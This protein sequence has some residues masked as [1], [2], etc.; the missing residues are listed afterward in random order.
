MNK[1]Q[2]IALISPPVQ[3]EIDRW[4]TKFPPERKRSAVLIALRLVQEQNGGWLS[5]ELM[6]AVAV[7]LDLPAIAVY[8]VVSFYTMFTTKPTGKHKIAVCN[9]ISCMLNGAERLI[10]HLEH[11]LKIAEGETS[12]DGLFTL[13]EVECLA[14]CVGAPAVQIDDRDYYENVT[15]EQM[16][17]LLDAI[18]QQEAEHA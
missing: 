6:D 15:C 3:A 5:I 18:R 14:A 7:Y 9:S 10:H 16:D 13:K 4:L 2:Q 8:E 1:Q 11:R 12:A 17:A